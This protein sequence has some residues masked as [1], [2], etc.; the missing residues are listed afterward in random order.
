MSFDTIKCLQTFLPFFNG[1]GTV[2]LPNALEQDKDSENE[3]G[4]F[5]INI[6]QKKKAIYVFIKMEN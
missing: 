5:V 4:M 6:S 2:L 3:E 1:I